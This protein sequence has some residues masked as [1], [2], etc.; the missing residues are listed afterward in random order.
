MTENRGPIAAVG[1]ACFRHRWWVVAVWVILAVAGVMASGRVFNGLSS[2]PGAN[3][4]ESVQA[5]TVLQ[6]HSTVGDEVI[7]EVTGVDPKAAGTATAVTAAATDLAT[8]P[9]VQ[10]VATPFTPSLPA[11]VR[12]ALIAHTGS[13]LL[14]EVTLTNLSDD[15][16]TT[17]VDAINHRLDSLQTALRAGGAPQADIAR[18]GSAILNQQVNHQVEHDL[19]LAEELSLPITLVLLIFVFG[20]LIA[21]GLPIIAAILS[22]FGAMLALLGFEHITTIDQNA[23]IVVTLLGLGL[24]IDY[25]LLLVA[26][27][28]EELAAG[29]EPA[30]AVGRAWASAGRTILFSALTV[31]GSLAGLTVFGVTSMT[32]LGTAGVSIA[33]I[34]MLV[35]LTAT[36]ALLG[37]ARKRIKPAK[38]AIN[39]DDDS[40]FFAGLAH[41]VQRRPVVTV[42]VTAAV[43]LAMAVPVLGTK[44]SVNSFTALPRS[45]SSVRVA[46]DLSTAYGQSEQPAA[47]VVAQMSAADLGTWAGKWSSYPGVSRVGQPVQVAAD[48]ATVDIYVSGD[49]EGTGARA[50]VHTLR[51][52]RP[53]AQSWVGGDAALLDDVLGLIG[54]RLPWAALVTVIAMMVLLFLMT[55]SIVVPIKAIIMNVLSLGATVGVMNLVFQHGTGSSLLHTLHT[56]SLDPFVL[57]GVLAFAFGLSMDYEVFLLSRIKEYVDAGVPS[58]VAVRRGL[59]RSGRV[60]T[61]AALCM[62][63]VFSCFLVGRVGNTQEIGLGL[64]AA[65]AVDA[66]LVRCVLVPATM[67]LL[68]KWNWWAPA[69][70]ARFHRRW[71][72]PA[73]AEPSVE[74]ERERVAIG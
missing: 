18:G 70:L 14:V 43:L 46:D 52:N 11:A 64:A 59:Q 31:A 42:V 67:T 22:V 7:G 23:T 73:V 53:D 4:L 44:V 5:Y 51:D 32:A 17:A 62:V 63:I 48:L 68:G 3:Q 57:V 65:I 66:T 60:I 41:V 54:D 49:P 45:L 33:G 61:S 28:R 30:E 2:E 34:A 19:G 74:T 20:G 37:L 27:Y 56:G 35:S 26:R 24:S 39:T 1:R 38:K 69:P 29:A 58:D 25:G 40:G 47:T 71:I 10:N 36:A 13:G 16:E 72:A 21:A 50:L 15:A 8:V 6:D 55:G 12:S 9:G